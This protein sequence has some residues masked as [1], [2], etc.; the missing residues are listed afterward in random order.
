MKNKTSTTVRI[1]V[2]LCVTA[3]LSGT[4]GCLPAED[5]SP[6]AVKKPTAE[7]T[8]EKPAETSPTESP[9]ST[10]DI[11]G[12]SLVFKD[13]TEIE[14][15][16]V[17]YAAGDYAAEVAPYKIKSDLS[18]IENLDQYGDFTAKQKKM[19]AQNGFVVMESGQNQLYH[20]YEQNEY[21]K[22]PSFVTVDSVLQ[23]YHLF[24]DYALR[25][26][27]ETELYTRL[28][29]L[30]QNMLDKSI[31]IYDTVQDPQIKEFSLG[32]AAYFAVACLTLGLELPDY[33]PEG[34]AA[35]AQK[36]LELVKSA[37]GVMDSYIFGFP[38]DY[39]M[40]TI[41]GHYTSSEELGKYFM[42][43]M[44]YGRVPFSFYDNDLETRN[45][46]QAIRA[47]LMT[48]TLFLQKDGNEVS[49]SG[50]WDDI[51]EP[52][53]FFVGDSD[54]YTPYELKDMIVASYGENPDLDRLLDEELLNKFY[55]EVDN[56]RVPKIQ[57]K[58]G[59]LAP[60]IPQGRQYR[61][62]GQR[63]VLDSDILMYL[64]KPQK[65]PMPKGLD[66]MGVLGS[67]RAYDILINDYGTAEQWEEY[68][69][70]FEE[71]KLEVESIKQDTWT[72][73]MYYGWLWTL[74]SEIKPLT[75]GYPS[76]MR[77]DAW[78][79]KSLNTALGSWAELRHDTIL[80]ADQSSAECGGDSPPIPRI[81]GYVEPNIEVYEKLLW[82]TQYSNE[83]LTQRGILPEDLKH[84]MS[85]FEDLLSF[86]INC[87]EKELRN[88][89]LTEEEYE[90]ILIYGGIL[91]SLTVRVSSYGYYEFR[92]DSSIAVIA[93]VHRVESTYLEEAVGNPAQIFVVVPINGKLYL[94]RGAVFTY[95]EFA[96]DARLTDEAWQKIID[97]GKAPAQPEW[98]DS[99]TGGEKEE[100]PV[101]VD[102]YST[103]C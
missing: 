92:A 19:L 91:E 16:V 28:I 77:N 9:Q 93:D 67:D 98:T 101:P 11:S 10:A 48:Y 65:R 44:W 43:L 35:L 79:D 21:L 15:A 100:I 22:I 81:K 90:Q 63:Y 45:E 102:P 74:Q 78:L 49:D 8:T 69:E 38:V 14:A 85:Q 13:R 103:G 40:F 99:Y 1:F 17:E 76:F 2:L 50:L 36:E 60:Q 82:L 46:E 37:E 83:N 51:Y 34:V 18:N 47:V 59:P 88:E 72:S 27:E 66:V 62:M 55:N 70:K 71:I 64:V 41:R 4:F 30:T 7:N 54:E 12:Y 75:E 84:N 53:S 25:T 73:N 52:T 56:A 33:L 24:F 3:F 96:S 26:L 20:I 80:Y 29:E 86:L 39:S 94:N 68:P 89:E 5:E 87:S 97:E 57:D 95:Y 6:T 42:T 23:V 32:N 31:Y 61:F 58:L